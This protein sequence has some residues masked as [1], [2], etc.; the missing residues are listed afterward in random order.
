MSSPSSATTGVND[1]FVRAVSRARAEFL[2]MPGLLLT[3]AQAARLWAFDDGLCRAV[4]AHLV[5]S[6]F[7]FALVAPLSPAPDGSYLHA[8]ALLAPCGRL[9][10]L[11]TV[12]A[13]MFGHR[14]D[15]IMRPSDPH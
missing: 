12:V 8:A 7:W 3:E 6:R 14:H 5:E 15:R 9:P 2:E 11:Y 4:L 10:Q 1:E 13:A